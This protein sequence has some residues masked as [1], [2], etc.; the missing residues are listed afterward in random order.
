LSHVALPFPVDDGLY[1]FDPD[2]A[3]IPG[4][5]LGS[6]PTRGERGLLVVSAADLTRITSNPFFGEILRRLDELI[7]AAPS[8]EPQSSDGKSSSAITSAS[9]RPTRAG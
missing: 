8:D 9:S 1:G 3:D 4:V 7:D 5:H 2:P 6:L